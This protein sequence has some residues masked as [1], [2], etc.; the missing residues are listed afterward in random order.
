MHL[1]N[2]DITSTGLDLKEYVSDSVLILYQDKIVKLN[3]TTKF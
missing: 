3:M 2:K 1:I